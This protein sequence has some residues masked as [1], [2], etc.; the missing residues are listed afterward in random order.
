MTAAFNYKDEF[1]YLT[2]T[3]RKTGQPREIE[4]WFVEHGG[5]YYLCAEGREKADWVQNILH[6]PA[7]I[8]WVHGKTYS[9]TGRILEGTA[10]PDLTA[11]GTALFDAK[12]Q[13]SDG[14]MVELCPDEAA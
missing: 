6:N 5:C 2:T 13:W 10:E 9:G 14:L 8:F 3:G 4:I 7:V 11:G 12:Y 1:L